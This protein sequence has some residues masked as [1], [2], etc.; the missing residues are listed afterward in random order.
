MK[1]G[2]ARAKAGRH[3]EDYVEGEDPDGYQADQLTSDEQFSILAACYDE[4]LTLER[5]GGDDS[6]ELTEDYQAIKTTLE[7]AMWTRSYEVLNDE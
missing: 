3:A 1:A 2:V 4:V 5:Y 7:T 6:D